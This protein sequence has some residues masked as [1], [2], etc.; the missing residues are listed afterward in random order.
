MT[1]A[2]CGNGVQVR[3]PLSAAPGTA[4]RAACPRCTAENDFALPAAGMGFPGFSAGDPDMPSGINDE[5]LYVACEMG[6]R[7]VEMM[8]DTGAQSSAA[9]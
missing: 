6:N 1:C 9:A 7:A 3:M 8:V 4:I 2:V 5:L